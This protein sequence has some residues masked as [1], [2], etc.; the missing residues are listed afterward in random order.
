MDNDRILD[1]SRKSF[2]EGDM[3]KS[4]MV[5]NFKGISNAPVEL[6]K[7][8]VLIGANAAG[9]SN[10]VDA[11]RFVHDA[12]ESGLTS[13]VG[14]RLGWENVLTREEKKTETIG[15]K[16]QWVP[17]ERM[18]GLTVAKKNYRP[19]VI[20][21]EFESS[22]WRK[23]VRVQS[24]KL[25]ATL[26]ER[27]GE[28][29]EEFDRSGGRA[30]IVS[31]LTLKN[32]MRVFTAPR[33]ARDRL[34]LEVGFATAGSS[35]LSEAIRSWRFYELNVNAARCPSTDVS[36]DNLL[37]DGGN[38]AAILDKLDETKASRLARTQ[39]R[40]TMA[41]LVPGFE[42]WRTAPQ[43]DGSLGFDIREKGI[44]RG[45]LPKMMSD[46]TIRLL[47][48][49]LVL[50]H[51]SS[52]ASLICIDE[53]ERYLHPQVLETLVELMRSVSEHTQLIVTTQSPELVKWLKPEEVLMVDKRDRRTQVKR[54]DSME[55]IS[56]FVDDLT[57][58]E[59][60]LGGYLAG[61][62]IL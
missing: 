44:S 36:S 5:T 23:R 40:E 6:G 35:F 60:W 14:R 21:Y 37:S 10:F 16:M 42:K 19:V 45:L 41:S 48:V 62:R 2:Q 1:D 7:L 8:N 38:L 27:S 29:R 20:N 9:K 4:I 12:L 47:C 34:F 57:M 43:S 11:M 53:P 61:G 56:R 46:G 24:E 3:L 17:D 22:C 52:E 33:Q 50:L 13:A 51:E 49:L 39:I 59:L 15:I 26:R 32:P 58:D 30:R 55:M 31:S 28:V 18:V 25:Q 54:A